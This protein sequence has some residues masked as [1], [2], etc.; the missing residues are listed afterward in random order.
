MLAGDRSTSILEPLSPCLPAYLARVCLR[1]G[2]VWCFHKSCISRVWIP[3]LSFFVLSPLVHFT[4]KF[5]ITR[6]SGSWSELLAIHCSFSDGC[7]YL[8]GKAVQVTLTRVMRT[9]FNCPFDDLERGIQAEPFKLVWKVP[10][11]KIVWKVWNKKRKK[12]NTKF[13]AVVLC[14]FLPLAYIVCLSDGIKKLL[15]CGLKLKGQTY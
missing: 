15:H 4:M 14:L 13:C 8:G 5:P 10:Y 2:A 7:K 3:R 6:S 12:K 9:D 1:V 11:S